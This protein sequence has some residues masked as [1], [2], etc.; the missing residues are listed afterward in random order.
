MYRNFICY[1]G[2]SS[3]GIQ[4][5]NELYKEMLP[6]KSKIGETYFSPI[7]NSGEERNF[8]TD[9]GYILGNV[10]N[11]IL[12]LTKDF[13]ADFLNSNNMANLYSVTRIEIDCALKNKHIKF[14]PVIFP[15]FS[16]QGN[17]NFI[18]NQNIIEKIWG[19]DAMQSI[20]GAMPIPYVF[21]YREKVYESIISEISDIKIS[22]KAVVF[23]F[24]GTLTKPQLGYNTW[25]TI[26][27]ELGYPSAV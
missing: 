13:F 20:V 22:K 6:L 10:E 2:G 1:R 17:T 12:I 3:A 27:T 15:D 26:W 25:E 21:Q 7:K 11:F 14:I 4:V 19:N 16:W 18:T 5:A 24:D 23:D 8:L 9:P